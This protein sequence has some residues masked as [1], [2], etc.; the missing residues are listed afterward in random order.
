MGVAMSDTLSIVNARPIGEQKWTSLWSRRPRWAQLALNEERHLERRRR[1]LVWHPGDRH[2]DPPTR[3]SVEGAPELERRF[4]GVEV[5]GLGVEVLDRL[6]DDPRTGRQHEVVVR[7]LLAVLEMDGL[8]RLVDL[9]D[10]SDDQGHPRVEQA[11][12]R[13]LEPVGAFATHRDVHEARLVCVL[14]GLVDDRDRDLAGLHLAT[15]LLDEEVGGECAAH[16][17]TQDEDP[18]H[19]LYRAF[20][21]MISS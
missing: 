15:Q 16:T 7:E 18:L 14:A 4:G 8:A 9:L 20:S 12:L 3:E 17:A 1:A 5:L 19:G 13:A 6:G 21:T 11:A 2:D 10:L